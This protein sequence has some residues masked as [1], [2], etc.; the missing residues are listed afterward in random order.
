MRAPNPT[1]LVPI[2]CVTLLGCGEAKEENWG[3]VFWRDGHAEQM[4]GGNFG[5]GVDVVTEIAV[6]DDKGVCGMRLS[7]IPK[8]VSLTV[9]A[10]KQPAE[11]TKAGAV[12]ASRVEAGA[13][14]LDEILPAAD[15][16]DSVQSGEPARQRGVAVGSM[17]KVSRQLAPPVWLAAGHRGGVMGVVVM[18][19]TTKRTLA[20]ATLPSVSKALV[21]VKILPPTDL[22][23]DGQR[24]F[25]LLSEEQ[26][27]VFRLNESRGEPTL[28]QLGTW[29]CLNSVLD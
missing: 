16:L 5:V 8:T 6:S 1:H 28:S 20:S 15:P 25:A 4:G 17:Q 29:S 13:W 26:V 27:A 7:N 23:G 22:D 12:L 21:S 24:E 14:R 18:D 19:H 9:Q 2:L 3:A 11:P 10:A